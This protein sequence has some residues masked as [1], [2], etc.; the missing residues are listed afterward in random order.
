ME[1][2]V[3]LM[4]ASHIIIVVV[5]QS[6]LKSIAD[7]LPKAKALSLQFFI[8]T[9]IAWIIILLAGGLKFEYSLL[10]ISIIGVVNAFGA[11]AQWQAYHFS[12]SKTSLFITLSG[13]IAVALA[14]IFLGESSLYKD[15]LL[16]IGVVS[17]LMASFLLAKKGGGDEIKTLLNG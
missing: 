3:F 13:V 6:F 8:A 1:A 10:L 9:V 14:A 16:I 2:L 12:L 4:I 15:P 11:Y 5:A 7:T 17:L